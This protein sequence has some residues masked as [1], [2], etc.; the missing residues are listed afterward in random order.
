MDELTFDETRWLT[1]HG[2]RTEKD[3]HTDLDGKRFVLMYIPD[4]RL[5]KERVYLGY[6]EPKSKY[7][8]PNAELAA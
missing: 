3:V 6:K 2:G 1:A 8:R 5:K 7:W 4:N